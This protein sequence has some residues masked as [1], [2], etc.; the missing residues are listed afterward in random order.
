MTIHKIEDLFQN[1][2][3]K[4]KRYRPQ[5]N[6]FSIMTTRG[7]NSYTELRDT[8]LK[9]INKYTKKDERG[10]EITTH[11]T[12]YI[13]SG[14]GF[15]S[16]TYLVD[17]IAIEIHNLAVLF[18]IDEINKRLVNIKLD[19]ETNKITELENIK[20]E[21]YFEYKI[22]SSVNGTIH[23]WKPKL[24]PD[25]K[26]EYFECPSTIDGYPIYTLED[27][28]KSSEIIYLNKERT[29]VDRWTDAD[30]ER[31]LKLKTLDLT[32]M[33]LSNIQSLRN[34][35][36]GDN[37]IELIRFGDNKFESLKYADN[38]I[39]DCKNLR[40][41]DIRNLMIPN[42]SKIENILCIDRN[43]SNILD[44]HINAKIDWNG[45]SNDTLG[46]CELFQLIINQSVYDKLYKLGYI[47][48]SKNNIDKVEEQR[49]K[50]KLL[51][52]KNPKYVI[53]YIV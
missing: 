47:K 17:D 51:D 1:K 14:S 42:G 39:H 49:N 40:Y 24:R 50:A 43:K 32:K 29:W 11:Y 23:G 34:M 19:A 13:N 44:K 4:I 10:R 25:F 36:S 52:I 28:F 7:K 31:F 15:G 38:F 6:L 35:V 9:V 26:D 27:T 3:V 33:D 22:I 53:A 2:S 41:L 30:K 48:I 46:L 16:N 5:L 20:V 18:G 21:N 37:N 45:I 8:T 12:L